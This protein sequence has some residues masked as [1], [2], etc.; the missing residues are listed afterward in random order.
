MLKQFKADHPIHEIRS[1]L[2][3]FGI[4]GEQSLQPIQSLS[5]GQKTRVVLAACA[6]MMPH[7]LMLDEVTN[8]LDMDSIEALGSALRRYQGAIVAVTHDQAFATM[9]A[10]QIFICEDKKIVEFKGSFQ[11]Y[12]DMVKSQIR[13]R[14][15]ASAGNKGIV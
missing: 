5:G 3:K 12:R 13:D 15:F 9:I 10:N 7:V 11:D 2:G 8:N 1:Q 14:F 4:N 6:M